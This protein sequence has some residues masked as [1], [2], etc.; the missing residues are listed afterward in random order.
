MDGCYGARADGGVMSSLE[1]LLPNAVRTPVTPEEALRLQGAGFTQDSTGNWVNSHTGY[2][3]NSTVKLYYRAAT[4]MWYTFDPTKGE[5]TPY[6]GTTA[7]G[8]PPPSSRAATAQATPAASSTTPSTSAIPGTS[9]VPALPKAK[10]EDKKP[11]ELKGKFKGMSLVAKKHVVDMK[12]WKARKEEAREGVPEI[13]QPVPPASATSSLPATSPVSPL[14]SEAPVAPKSPSHLELTPPKSVADEDWSLSLAP[15]KHVC[16]LCKRQ[17]QSIETMK[18]HNSFSELHKQNLEKAIQD[19][20][21][22]EEGITVPLTRKELAERVERQIKYRDRA[23]ELRAI[24]GEGGTKGKGG[25]KSAWRGGRGRGGG[26]GQER[27]RP[28]VQDPHQALPETNK[29]HEMLRAMGWKEG[30]SLGRMGTGITAPIEVDARCE[31]QGLGVATSRENAVQPN[32]DYKT[33]N[34]KRARA[35][36]EE[37]HGVLEDGDLFDQRKAPKP[38]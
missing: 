22:L 24:F 37:E 27:N 11:T 32:D 25:R 15:D 38:R 14:V 31:R 21:V 2:T 3:Y 4:G 7:T 35:R 33:I 12:K 16:L 20:G 17:F 9:S 10:E 6:Q 26:R 13:V 36:W 18:K 8:E 5:Y 30:E 23:T 1:T 34:L 29:G 28:D 19:G